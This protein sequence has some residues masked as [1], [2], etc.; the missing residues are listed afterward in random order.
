[1]KKE[2]RSFTDEFKLEVARMV[3][4]QG[5]DVPIRLYFEL[6]WWH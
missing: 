3:A 5:M 4:D 6:R 2:R 1:M